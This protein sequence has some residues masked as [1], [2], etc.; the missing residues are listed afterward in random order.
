MRD[1]PHPGPAWQNLRA[2]TQQLQRLPTRLWPQSL[3]LLEELK[4]KQL[5]PDSFVCSSSTASLGRARAWR[6]ALE[7]L[8]HAVKGATDEL[9]AT[10]GAPPDIVCLNAAAASSVNANA[11]PQGIELF[12]LARRTALQPDS[13]TARSLISLKT[14]W[15]GALQV[16]S[17]MSISDRLPHLTAVIESFGTAQWPIALVLFNHV[18]QLML[19]S[20]A[21]VE[22]I[23]KTNCWSRNLHL[24]TQAVPN[25]VQDAALHRHVLL[26]C[27]R[28]GKLKVALRLLERCDSR[29]LQ[30]TV[31]MR[32]AF[33]AACENT[34]RWREALA[35]VRMGLPDRA[36]CNSLL[37]MCRRRSAWERSLRLLSGASLSLSLSLLG[38]AKRCGWALGLALFG[39][40]AARADRADGA[41]WD[42]AIDSAGADGTGWK[43]ALEL[44]RTKP[45]ISLH[46][47][48][49][50]MAALGLHGSRHWRRCTDLLG[51]VPSTGLRLNAI[52]LSTVLA[53]V[54]EFRH[55]EWASEMMSA[56]RLQWLEVNSYCFNA[57]VAC[58][59]KAKAWR[60]AL[61]TMRCMESWAVPADR[62][63]AASSISSC[64][65][66]QQWL[67]AIWL[68]H[69]APASAEEVEAETLTSAIQHT[70][71]LSGVRGAPWRWALDFL[72]KDVPPELSEVLTID[73]T[74][75]LLTSTT[76]SSHS[77]RKARRFLQELHWP[78]A[79]VQRLPARVELR[80]AL[81]AAELLEECDALTA[82]DARSFSRFYGRFNLARLDEQCPAALP[83]WHLKSSLQSR[84][85]FSEGVLDL[86]VSSADGAR[87]PIW[88]PMGCSD[89]RSLSW[90]S[91]GQVT[92]QLVACWTSVFIPTTGHWRKVMGH[93]E[94]GEDERLA[95]VSG[96][97]R[98]GP[99]AERQALIRILQELGGDNLKKRK[100]G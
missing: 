60:F 53:S 58:S 48:G 63:S 83:S 43:V 81:M 76:H 92:A 98:R 77:F 91:P 56:M 25:Q 10:N 38:R 69:T 12:E 57:L 78:G 45:T 39:Q 30:P 2:A 70:A 99:H 18:Q 4:Q 96:E 14:A 65:K 21:F 72:E 54:Q 73:A 49:A 88:K 27:L 31:A 67:W 82:E 93:C 46:G 15:A 32:G 19:A 52:T 94:D 95:A 6:W 62:Y 11:W 36:M 23:L 26:S 9:G 97:G 44:L 50:A 35:A 13:E 89:T 1:G 66:A 59:E 61:Q 87:E 37:C 20:R 41:A 42:A 75:H 8:E 71:V 17:A 90:R 68:F 22:A 29:G 55:W 85:L 28:S 64:E 100:R 86:R 3:Q 24:L 33:V 7:L 47:Y 84:L 79:A 34:G 40:R 16:V 80:E 51:E 74:L 5:Q